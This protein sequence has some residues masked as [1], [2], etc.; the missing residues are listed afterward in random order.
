MALVVYISISSNKTIGVH[1][2]SVM[3]FTKNLPICHAA[4]ITVF[5]LVHNKCRL[6]GFKGH[7]LCL[8]KLPLAYITIFS[9]PFNGKN[10]CILFNLSD[11]IIHATKS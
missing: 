8:Y 9:V 4:F 7:I 11:F 3:N 2:P 5:Y 6:M 1:Q 10:E